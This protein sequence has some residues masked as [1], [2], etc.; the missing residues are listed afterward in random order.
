MWR[1]HWRIQHGG[2]PTLTN[3][4]RVRLGKSHAIQIIG[5]VEWQIQGGLETSAYG[6]TL[7]RRDTAVGRIWAALQ[8]L[9]LA[10][11]TWLIFT[12]DHGLAM[13]RAKCTL[14][15][16]GLQTALIMVAPAFGLTGGR[17]CDELIR[18]V[19]ITPTILDMLGLP[20]SPRLQGRSFASLLR[21]EPYQPRE[22]IFAEKTFHTAYEPQ[23]AIRTAR[24]KLIWN[25]EAGIM[26]VPGDIMH[27]PIY[28]EMLDEITVEHKPF[29]LYDLLADPA[30]R[31]NQIANPDYADIFLDLRHHLLYCL[32]VTGDP[33]LDGPIASPFYRRGLEQLNGRP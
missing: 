14:Y 16:P 30:E 11:D 29:E 6:K 4:K 33:L 3:P 1:W 5:D 2:T 32:R 8:E 26:N 15:D 18:N 25:V 20:L 13:P 28:P 22:R 31:V 10:A 27:S 7:P 9:G 17:V 12:A 19:D 24:Y 23:R 21:G